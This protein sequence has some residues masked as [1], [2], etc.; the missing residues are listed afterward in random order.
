MLHAVSPAVPPHATARVRCPRRTSRL[1]AHRGRCRGVR[2]P[3]LPRQPGGPLLFLQVQPLRPHTLGHRRHGR[4]RHQP[5]RSRRLP[6]RPE[7]R[8]PARRRPSLRRSRNRQGHRPRDRAP[9]WPGR[10]GGTAGPALPVQPR[11]DRHRHRRRRPRLHRHGG[12]GGVPTPS[13][14][15]PT[16]AAAS[17]M[18]AWRS[19][20]ERRGQGATISAR[21]VEA[22]CRQTGRVFTGVRPYRRGAAFLRGPRDATSRS[23]GSASGAPASRKPSS[24]RPNPRPRSRRS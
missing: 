11:R 1:G 21:L 15:N 4:V 9:A 2:G 23:T 3:A 12:A 17:P 7:G 14:A 20:W 18:P 16:S 8:L 13:P 10:S 5:G 6:P 19:N 22:L 24:A